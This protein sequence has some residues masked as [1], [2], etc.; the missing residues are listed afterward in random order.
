MSEKIIHGYSGS[1]SPDG[2]YWIKFKNFSL[3]IFELIPKKNGG[4]K[5]GKVKVRVIGPSDKS[6]IVYAKAREIA[7][8]LDTG[9]YSGPKSIRMR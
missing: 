2:K 9:T 5:H 6:D 3:G 8:Q 1:C 4:F 7:C